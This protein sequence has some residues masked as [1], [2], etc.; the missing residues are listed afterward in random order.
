MRDHI[1]EEL[2]EKEAEVE[3]LSSGRQ[4]H[5]DTT[6]HPA[7]IHQTKYTGWRQNDF[8]VLQA[9]E[10]LHTL[11]CII[12]NPLDRASARDSAL[13]GERVSSARD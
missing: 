13:D 12:Q 1:A 7:V 2:E 8:N 9:L 5:S 4:S 6:L 3:A 11:R 10:D